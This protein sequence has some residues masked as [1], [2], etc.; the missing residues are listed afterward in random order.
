[1]RIF[2]PA[3]LA[4]CVLVLVAP[5]PRAAAAEEIKSFSFEPSS[6][7]AGG[8]PD[9]S[10]HV[11][12][13]PEQAET[14]ER[15]SFDWP[16]GLN[17][18][19]QAVPTCSRADFE[20]GECA[21]NSQIGLATIREAH[22][23]SEAV[24]GTVPVFAL[25]PALGSFAEIGFVIPGIDEPVYG[26]IHQHNSTDYLTSL[27][28]AEFPEAAPLASLDLTLWGVP[29]DL[30][31]DPERFPKGTNGCPGL[32][33]TSCNGPPVQS[34]L[35]PFPQ[36][37]SPTT[38]PPGHLTSTATL[39]THQDPGNP[40][41]ANA[42]FFQITGCNQLSFNPASFPV[43]T[44]TEARSQTGLDLNLE[45]PQEQSA[46]IPSPSELRA[47]EVVFEG[48][49]VLGSGPETMNSCPETDVHQFDGSGASLCPT[50]SLLGTA[51][52]D[53]AL[54][55]GPISGGLYYGGEFEGGYLA[56]LLASGFNYDVV[57][58]VF[59]E[60]EP[61]TGLAVIALESLPQIPISLLSLHFST[62]NE[63]LETVN[64]CGSFKVTTYFE[65]WDSAF[66]IQNAI[67]EF[68][69]E[70]GPGG[71]PCPGPASAIGLSLS[72]TSVL[73]DGSA[74]TEATAHV[75]DANGGPVIGDRV[76]FRSSDPGER[77]GRVT[78]TGDGIYGATITAS[79]TP[80]TVTITAVDTSVTPNVSGSTTLEQTGGSP[81]A[82]VAPV[83]KITRHPAQRSHSRRPVF[84]FTSS[85]P[86][87]R[88]RCSVDAK[89][90]QPCTSPMRLKGLA[91][92]KHR[93]RV[94]AVSPTGQTGKPVIFRF[95]VLNRNRPATR[96][97]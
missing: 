68:R 80:G 22:E 56:Y 11:G 83:A 58:P 91:P 52:V 97:R 25:E 34:S 20:S 40:D 96:S 41:T 42:Q 32:A 54:F 53:G 15:I 76:E 28:L 93:F 12:L 29:A 79:R 71:T 49:V 46:T 59:I 21:S 47:T 19:P 72:P 55:S 23:G 18:L 84:A 43:L 6:A 90:F 17:F 57:L 77:I 88:F 85:V 73:A 10:I 81:P 30:S 24:L 67:N 37:E 33:D 64:E 86:R 13:G 70:S 65:A 60:E 48:G 61:E 36:F 14:A 8:H 75:T 50:D 27:T 7:Q 69:L 51:M 35:Q 95:R 87:S 38:C 4:F 31:H 62:A 94:V 44:T 89:P 2:T 78:E 39:E 92:G 3:A 66:A 74:T 9:L 1:M 45:V 82:V 5:V 26:D 63:T 16:P